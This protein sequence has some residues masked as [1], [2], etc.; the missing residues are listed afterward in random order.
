LKALH[1]ICLLKLTEAMC[2]AH[3]ILGILKHAPN[4]LCK[5]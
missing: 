4:P 5:S 1:S 3:E 2:M